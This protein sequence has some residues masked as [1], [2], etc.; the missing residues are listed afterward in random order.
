MNMRALAITGA[1]TALALGAWAFVGTRAGFQEARVP[2]TRATLPVRDAVTYD[3]LRA[4]SANLIA[5]AL[6]PSAAG[7]DPLQVE[8]RVPRAAGTPCVV[9]L[10][11]DM[12]I[13]TMSV[14]DPQFTYTP[15]AGCPGP[16]AKVK[17]IVEMSG[18]REG[19]Q[20]TSTVHL[21][22]VD[23]ASPSRHMTGALWVGAPQITDD[24]PV[25]RMERDLTE[26]GA[27]FTTPRAGFFAGTFDNDNHDIDFIENRGTALLV[28]YPATA[29]TP[30]QRRANVVLGVANEPLDTRPTATLTSIFPRNV[31]RA[32]LDI[33]AKVMGGGT[34]GGPSR[35]WYACA[36]DDVLADFPYLRN[37][38]AIGDARLLTASAPQGCGGGS[39]REV[40][41]RIDGRLVGLAPVFPWLGSNINNNFRGVLDRPAPS[42]QA[43]NLLPFRVDLTPYAGVLNNGAEHEV[44]LHLRDADSAFVSGQLLLYTDPSRAIVPGAVTRNTLVESNP[45]VTRA[46]TE[47]DNMVGPF[48]NHHLVGSVTTR[49]VRPFTIEG[50]VDSSRGRIRSTVIQRNYFLSTNTYDVMSFDEVSPFDDFDADFG[51]QVRLTSSVDR[52]TRSVLGTTLLREDKL[53]STY[54][55]VIDYRHA[56]GNRS[57]GEFG[58]A[59]TDR[60]D[61]DVHQARALRESQF[62]RGTPR[63]THAVTDIF[64]GSH[65]YLAEFLGG[66]GVPFDWNS[67]REY[68]YT[69]NF[70]GCYSAGITTENQVL[71]TRTRGTD[72]PFGN[73]LRWWSHP[74]GSP[75]SMNWAPVP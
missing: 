2:T 46:F 5:A 29:A 1:A 72:C 51:Q 35:Y 64:D 6:E 25:W 59:G 49:S 18:P 10:F 27:L 56:G 23:P 44:A 12:Q 60:V 21:A 31:L 57:D 9:E 53:Y 70:A 38:Y 42:V 16:W 48:L 73:Q 7:A 55:L 37:G 4:Q 71:Q 67:Q 54:P 63:Y 32:Y 17:L 13:P 30:A 28:F 66:T 20:P 61:L 50:Y 26:Y 3:G 58:G 41:V 45:T 14:Y 43:L 22:F 47:T 33:T 40:E 11:R 34:Q 74:D 52:T 75:D 24:I 36:P 65:H 15:P 68:L 39:Y 19:G 69:D 62:R 8:P